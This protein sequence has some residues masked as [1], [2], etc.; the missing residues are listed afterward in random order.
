MLLFVAAVV[1]TLAW[2][3]LERLL[4][5]GGATVDASVGPIGFDLHVISLYFR[6]NP[7]SILGLITGALIFRS[8]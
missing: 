3:L 7:G 5:L 6:F 1:G 8:L 2:G 4:A